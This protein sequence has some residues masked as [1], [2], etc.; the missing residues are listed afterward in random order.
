MIPIHHATAYGL[1]AMFMWTDRYRDV[2]V[3][4][5][6]MLGSLSFYVTIIVRQLDVYSVPAFLFISGYFIAFMCLLAGVSTTFPFS[7]L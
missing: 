7:L 6:D 1:Q 4:N 2:A 5:Y 3:P